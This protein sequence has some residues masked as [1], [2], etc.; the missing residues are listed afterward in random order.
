MKMFFGL[1]KSDLGKCLLVISALFF[2]T[3]AFSKDAD[4]KN[5]ALLAALEALTSRVE[6]LESITPSSSVEGRSYCVVVNQ[7]VMIGVTFA[8]QEQLNSTVFKRNATFANGV[9][10]ATLSGSASRNIQNDLGIVTFDQFDPPS[11]IN[12]AYTQFGNR[13]ALDIVDG[14]G[15]PTS[16]TWYVSKDGSVIHGTTT[17]EL[18]PIGDPAVVTLGVTTTVTLVEGV[19]D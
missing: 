7:L 3:N 2:S 18:P 5:D 11:Q 17:R 6:T 15:N 9:Y 4:L 16:A 10:T 14:N 13:L 8:E 1:I 19:C 12:G